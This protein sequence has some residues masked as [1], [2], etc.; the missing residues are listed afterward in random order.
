MFKKKFAFTMLFKFDQIV[1]I[2]NICFFFFFEQQSTFVSVNTENV[3]FMED[4]IT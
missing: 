1:N 4:L 3:N 2:V